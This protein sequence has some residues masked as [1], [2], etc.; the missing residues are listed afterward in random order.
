MKTKATYSK[1]SNFKLPVY[2]IL[3]M[4]RYTVEESGDKNV[5]FLGVSI[6]HWFC[7]PCRYQEVEESKLERL[8]LQ[9]E[10]SQMILAEEAFKNQARKTALERKLDLRAQIASKA[11]R[12]AAEE[13]DR[14]AEVKVRSFLGSTMQIKLTPN[15]FLWDSMI[16]AKYWSIPVFVE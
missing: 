16:F 6:T 7:P 15:N 2:L 5:L 14:I 3:N 9:E 13:H 10:G 8:Q 4:L 12:R 1:K 11:Q